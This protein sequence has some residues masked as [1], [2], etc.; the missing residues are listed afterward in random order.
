[1]SKVSAPNISG[2]SVKIAVP[3]A[4]VSLSATQ[5]NSGLAVMPLKPSEPPHFKPSTSWLT[6]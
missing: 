2:T 6:F 4:A 3:P 5:P 1:M